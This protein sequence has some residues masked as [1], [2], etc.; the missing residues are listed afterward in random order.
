MQR[1][2]RV[3]RAQRAQRARRASLE[4]VARGQCAEPMRRANAPGQCIEPL[5][6]NGVQPNAMI[7]VLA[8]DK[9][10]PGTNYL[11]KRSLSLWGLCWD[12]VGTPLRLFWEG[13]TE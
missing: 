4:D 2:Q 10:I 11:T 7:Q 9:V 5:T 8:S 1:V 13:S 3:Q 12:S 6:T